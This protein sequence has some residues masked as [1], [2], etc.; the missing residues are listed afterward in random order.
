MICYLGCASLSHFISG[1]VELQP[2][3]FTAEPPKPITVVEGNNLSLEWRYDLGVGGSIRRID[4]HETSSSPSV[5]ILEVSS[6]GHYPVNQTP[7]VL[8]DSYNGRLQANVTETQT[9]ITI[10]GANRTVDS[11]E[12]QLDVNPVGSSRISS[13]VTVLVQCK[14][15]STSVSIFQYYVMCN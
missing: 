6:V 13:A 15:K 12:Y 11:K 3:E 1:F 2:P 5:L 8:V 9:S 14:Y 7:D 4:F 10:L